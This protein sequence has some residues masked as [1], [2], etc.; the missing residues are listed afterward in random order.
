MAKED[1]DRQA[2][3]NETRSLVRMA[4]FGFVVVQY[5]S[6]LK[7]FVWTR[8]LRTRQ[9]ADLQP[10]RKDPSWLR[11]ALLDRPP[12]RLGQCNTGCL[13]RSRLHRWNHPTC[14]KMLRLSIHRT[15][16]GTQHRQAQLDFICSRVG[17]NS[18][19]RLHKNSSR[20][21]LVLGVTLIPCGKESSPRRTSK[22]SNRHGQRNVARQMSKI[23]QPTLRLIHPGSRDLL[24]LCRAMILATIGQPS[25]CSENRHTFRRQ[26]LCSQ[27]T[28]VFSNQA[29]QV[30]V[31]KRLQCMGIRFQVLFRHDVLSV[32]GD[33][34]V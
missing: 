15:Q 32:R 1:A 33:A 12:L 3:P 10:Q 24:K 21:S 22:S 20:A 8:S 4:A 27:R 9:D 25:V 6:I 2:K 29:S 17:L 30:Q 14:L 7:S 23:G 19:L 16:H 13:G 28:A 26:I 11:L 18:L 5:G 31:E 34:G